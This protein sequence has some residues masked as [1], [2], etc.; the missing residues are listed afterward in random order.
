MSA[1][2]QPIIA[3]I[4]RQ[5]IRQE[6]TPELFVRTTNKSNN[7][8]YAFRAAQAPHTMR[9]VGRLREESFRAGGGGT[10]LECDVDKYD[11]MDDG[12]VQLIVWNPELE[13]VMGGYRYILGEAVLRH[14]EQTDALATSHMFSFS[15]EFVRDYLPYTIEL[16][17]SFVS[18]EFQTTRAGLMSSIYTLDNLWDGLGAL[19]VIYPE[20]KYFLGKV[21]MYKTYDKY[22]RNLILKFM[23]IYFGD[24]DQLVRPMNPVE[25]DIDPEEIDRLF[26]KNDLKSDYRTLK[27][28]VR[29]HNIN[30]PPLFNAYMSLTPKI[31][32]FGTA[33]NDEFGDVEE[34]GLL[35]PIA[36]II[37][38]KKERHI[39]TYQHTRKS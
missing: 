35:T 15:E 24:K 12:Y 18:H 3:P 10:G 13:K 33:I 29:K 19:T 34:T 21:T 5:L 32:I 4:D 37:P 17:R 25:V 31:R 20:I 14:Q 11:L 9:E 2:V 6:L 22:C 39:D 38:E 30:I 16:G 1:T 8:I 28:E 26:V 23:E 36:D 27:A 7:E